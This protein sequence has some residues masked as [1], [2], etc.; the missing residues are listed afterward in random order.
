MPFDLK[1]LLCVRN[2]TLWKK[3]FLL[4][5]YL[6]VNLCW[7]KITLKIVTLTGRTVWP[8]RY[9]AITSKNK[10][11]HF[12]E[13]VDYLTLKMSRVHAQISKNFD[14]LKMCRQVWNVNKGL[15]LALVPEQKFVFQWFQFLALKKCLKANWHVATH[16]IIKYPH[17]TFVKKQLF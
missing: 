15:H 13:L 11:Y 9:F 17:L 12:S 1:A 16:S 4:K 2:C 10:V 14:A 6:G 5:L 8:H 3:E 7:F